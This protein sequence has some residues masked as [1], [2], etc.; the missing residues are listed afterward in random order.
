[1]FRKPADFRLFCELCESQRAKHGISFL[2]VLPSDRGVS[3]LLAAER[4]PMISRFLKLVKGEYSRRINN[5]YFEEPLALFEGLAGLRIGRVSE[6]LGADVCPVS[7]SNNWRTHYH[8]FEVTP[9]RL[10]R[11]VAKGWAAAKEAEDWARTKKAY[12][13]R[14]SE[15]A[16]LALEFIA[17]GYGDALVP[18]PGQK[19]LSPDVKTGRR[20]DRLVNSAF[21]WFFSRW[22]SEYR[23]QTQ[24]GPLGKGESRGTEPPPEDRNS[25][26]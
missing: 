20:R 19:L 10:E 13:F 4:G 1:M 25:P 9:E 17:R 21:W 22:P 6:G 14:Q 24:E 3:I 2:W 5:Q 18:A 23:T 15:E 11:W 16:L 26:G 7:R 8:S 12:G